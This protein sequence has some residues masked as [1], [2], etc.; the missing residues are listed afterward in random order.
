MSIWARGQPWASVTQGS[1]PIPPMAAGEVCG[2]CTRTHVLLRGGAMPAPCGATQGEESGHE[3]RHGGPLLDAPPDIPQKWSRGPGGAWTRH[4]SLLSK[5]APCTE[6]EDK[7][8]AALCCA[9][10]REPA[11]ALPPH[12]RPEGYGGTR[13]PGKLPLRRGK[14]S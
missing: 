13:E 7:L 2:S 3:R 10:E 8:A 9:E 11:S 5:M 12:C 14:M 6:R 1:G 4:H